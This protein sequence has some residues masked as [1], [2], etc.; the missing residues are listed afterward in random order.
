MRYR[1]HGIGR[2]RAAQSAGAAPVSR[3]TD[4]IEGMASEPGA[5]QIAAIRQA[6]QCGAVAH[7]IE[8]R[9]IH[10]EHA[11]L[12]DPSLQNHETMPYQQPGRV[13]TVPWNPFRRPIARETP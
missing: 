2:K 12:A 1:R 8:G 4:I 11:R 10:F 7:A 3:M 5:A 13:R 9:H 6:G